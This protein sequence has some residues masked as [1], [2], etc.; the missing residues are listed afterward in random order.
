MMLK[1]N[2]VQKWNARELRKVLH[3]EEQMQMV[4]ISEEY[5]AEKSS[6]LFLSVD[7]QIDERIYALKVF[8][9]NM[10]F[11]L[12]NSCGLKFCCY[13][14]TFFSHCSNISPS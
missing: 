12:A 6:P 4:S 8:I 7:I 1:I 10:V 9:S 14:Y 3:Q 11:F 5:Q 13:C 2:F